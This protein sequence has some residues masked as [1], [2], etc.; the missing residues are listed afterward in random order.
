MAVKLALV[1]DFVPK[2]RAPFPIVAAS[3]GLHQG[4]V[5]FNKTSVS[6]VAVVSEWYSS[7]TAAIG[8]A[9]EVPTEQCPLLF[10]ITSWCSSHAHQTPF[11]LAPGLKIRIRHKSYWTADKK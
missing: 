3:C 6:I 5:K 4:I 2:V 1:I 11:C 8:I 9:K 7:Q 10:L